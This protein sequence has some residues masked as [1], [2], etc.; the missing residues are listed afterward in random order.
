MQKER[1]YDFRKRLLQVHRK[2]IRDHTLT[3]TAEET[4]LRDGFRIVLLSDLHGARY[5]E[6]QKYLGSALSGMPYSCVVCAPPLSTVYFQ[7][8]RLAGAKKKEKDR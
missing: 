1:N 3:P 7:V 5:G 2:D 6:K 4:E 8:K